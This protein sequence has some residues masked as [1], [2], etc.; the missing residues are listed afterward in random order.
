[1]GEDVDDR[2]TGEETATREKGG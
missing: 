1:V 2:H